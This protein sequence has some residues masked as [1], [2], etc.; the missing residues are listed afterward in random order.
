MSDEMDDL[1]DRISE[2]E[3]M[4]LCDELENSK[5]ELDGKTMLKHRYLGTHEYKPR[6]NAWFNERLTE[7][8]TLAERLKA[9]KKWWEY[10]DVHSKEYYPTVLEEIKTCATPDEWREAVRTAW[11]LSDVLWSNRD[12][13]LRIFCDRDR[14]AGIST[15]VEQDYFD[16]QKDPLTVYRGCLPEH[17]DGL[18]WSLKKMAVEHFKYA[19]GHRGVVFSGRVEKRHVLAY[20]NPNNEEFEVIV[21]PEHVIQRQNLG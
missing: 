7:K 9:E 1:L 18:S 5:V 21:N 4:D 17:V 20:M 6:H 2:R 13:W 12:A 3:Q 10:V 11:Y 15:T 14:I 16:R 8:R 19:A